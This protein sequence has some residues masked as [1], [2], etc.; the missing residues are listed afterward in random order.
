MWRCS[1]Q[2]PEP[3]SCPGGET[4]SVLWVFP[5]APHPCAQK[6]VW[7]K[8]GSLALQCS[9]AQGPKA[10]G[11]WG[12]V[13]RG[14][15]C[16]VTVLG[17]C[18]HS[19]ATW[20]MLSSQS[21]SWEQ[22]FCFVEK[23]QCCC[24]QTW[25]VQA[26]SSKIPFTQGTE[27]PFLGLAGR[28]ELFA[29]CC[30]VDMRMGRVVWSIPSHQRCSEVSLASPSL[31][32]LLLLCSSLDAMSVKDRNLHLEE[33]VIKTQ[34]EPVN[35]RIE[36]RLCGHG[37][38]GWQVRTCSSGGYCAVFP[39]LWPSSTIKGK[40]LKIQDTVHVLKL[41]EMLRSN[42]TPRNTFL[43]S[44]VFVRGESAVHTVTHVCWSSADCF[45][46]VWL[47]QAILCACL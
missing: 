12:D 2:S 21:Q 43:T 6:A 23:P 20:V 26:L 8:S 14:H 19:S 13:C 27:F 18:C 1:C 39:P 36:D 35:V 37:D 25:D 40:T 34:Q 38:R 41:F 28:S 47:T 10:A 5:Q 4:F 30:L 22:D 3:W 24:S 29:L 11:L 44:P 45:G 7:K 46:K 42:C 16:S 17:R 31:V 33:L 15:V 9:S 32:G